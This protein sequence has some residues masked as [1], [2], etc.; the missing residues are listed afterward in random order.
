MYCTGNSIPLS[1]YQIFK[2]KKKHNNMYSG[3]RYT[4]KHTSMLSDKKKHSERLMLLA[5]NNMIL[6][7]NK[8]SIL[9][10]FRDVVR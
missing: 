4:R 8:L 9:R 10:G 3:K 2:K 1:V 6:S 7:S 5:Y